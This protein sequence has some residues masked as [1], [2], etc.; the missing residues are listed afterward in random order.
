MSR[1]N[2]SIPAYRKHRVYFESFLKSDELTRKWTNL[3]LHCVPYS[4]GYERRM[5]A[6]LIFPVEHLP[7]RPKC[8]YINIFTHRSLD[9]IALTSRVSRGDL[10]NPSHL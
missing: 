1:L 7:N 3:S 10:R 9:A 6:Y 8:K 5:N 2:R 4:I